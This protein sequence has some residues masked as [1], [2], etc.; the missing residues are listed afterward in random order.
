MKQFKFIIPCL[1]LITS[2]QKRE[3]LAPLQWMEGRWI[4][5]LDESFESTETWEVVSE[6]EMKGAGLS[7]ENG[8]TIFYEALSIVSE[9]S[10]IYYIANIGDGDVRF[11]LTE[12]S[13]NK[14]T[15][16]NP[17]HDFPQRIIYEME[18]GYMVA[19][20]EADDTTLEFKFKK[21]K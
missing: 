18:N 7:A 5:E 16:E 4:N 20:A 19:F 6:F 15:F 9:T 2:C 17:K 1:F 11:K 12:S 14:W 13:E 3:S 8:D 21:S 10:G